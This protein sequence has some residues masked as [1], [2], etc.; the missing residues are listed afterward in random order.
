MATLDELL[1]G[2][3]TPR[4]GTLGVLQQQSVAQR[5]EPQGIFGMGLADA[6]ARWGRGVQDKAAQ[7]TPS[8]IAQSLATFPKPDLNAEMSDEQK[9][10]LIA[11][12]LTKDYMNFAPLGMI[13]AWHGSPHNIPM[14]RSM[15]MEKIGTGEGAQAYGH[16][17]YTA[18]SPEVAKAYSTLGHIKGNISTIG[19]KN[20]TDYY[21]ALENQAARL[22]P[23]KAAGHY[24]KLG[25][26][27]NLMNNQTP[28]EV[29]KF[30]QDNGY[31]KSAID[32]FKSDV[33]P[34]YDGAGK[35]YKLELS[36]PD[37]V[38]EAAT[39]LSPNDFLHWDLPMSQ[40]PERVQAALNK[41]AKLPEFRQ[42]ML[43]EAMQPMEIN[44]TKGETIHH[45]LNSYFQGDRAK[46]TG[47]LNRAGIPGIRYLDGGS[48]GAGQGT[49]NYVLFD[50]KLANIVGKE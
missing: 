4:R 8:N 1:A 48:R 17:L 7:F 18:E 13:N 3:R 20:I 43:G 38:K 5:P 42:G 6:L 30:A 15:L 41:I 39:P 44:S 27:E 29:V 24:E 11:N 16:G 31:S 12:A 28:S 26:L 2:L 33:I 22:P 23:Q 46:V 45:I 25:M 47:L 49:H 10:Q 36:H 14:G 37:P 34:K 9:R 32:W 19:G 40:Q 35:L 50:P 21:S